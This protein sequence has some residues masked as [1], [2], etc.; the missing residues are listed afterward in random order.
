MTNADTY[1]DHLLSLSDQETPTTCIDVDTGRVYVWNESKGQWLQSEVVLSISA[2]ERL[3]LM[4]PNNRKLW[5]KKA[6]NEPPLELHENSAKH[7][8]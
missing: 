7:P 5:L 3:A 1:I 2:R 4:F 6:T 8:R